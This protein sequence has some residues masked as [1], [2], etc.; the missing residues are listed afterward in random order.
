MCRKPEV[1]I[2]TIEGKEEKERNGYVVSVKLKKKENNHILHVRTYTQMDARAR[3]HTR[4][5]TCTMKNLRQ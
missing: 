4:T 2:A 3:R 5:H 1:K